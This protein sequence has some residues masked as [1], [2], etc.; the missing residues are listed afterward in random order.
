MN[1]GVILTVSMLLA[2][3]S[4]AH[5]S[6]A[7]GMAHASEHLWLLLAVVPVLALL[8]PLVLR[9]LRKRNPR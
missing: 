1:R 6:H 2:A 8:R 5:V 7:E 3:N 4:Q 9:I